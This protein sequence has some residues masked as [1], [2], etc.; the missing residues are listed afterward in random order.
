MNA[1]ALRDYCLSLGSGVEE[2]MPF[3]AFRAATGVLAFYVAGH[4]FCY[5]DLDH[6]GTV[7]LKCAPDR[8]AE[9]RERHPFISA[10][11]NLSPRHWI[12]VDA[13][14][15]PDSLLQTLV[16]DSYALVIKQ[17]ARKRKR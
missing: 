13:T 16:A 9:L 10:P 14:Q 8:I 17:Y 2:K 1:E 4:M 3:Q 15:A 7:N 5:Y 12:G 11:Y 6:F